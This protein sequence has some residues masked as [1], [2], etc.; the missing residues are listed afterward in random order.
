[1]FKFNIYIYE[2]HLSFSNK[3]YYN[4]SSQI[5]LVFRVPVSMNPI[6][7]ALCISQSAQSKIYN[8]SVCSVQWGEA[9]QEPKD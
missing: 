7:G 6:K 3:T 5:R 4:F 9:P 2:T 8:V 1:M